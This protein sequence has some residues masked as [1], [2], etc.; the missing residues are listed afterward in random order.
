[1]K[2]KKVLKS[3]AIILSIILVPLDIC[4]YMKMQS[5]WS[6][7]VS[8]QEPYENAS[9]AI[10]GFFRWGMLIG[11]ILLIPMVWLEYLLI[12]LLIKIYNKFDGLK[13]LFF[14]FTTICCNSN[15][16]SFVYKNNNIYYN[17]TMI[18]DNS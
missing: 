4:L 9:L 11:G 15:N 10:V 12:N 17:V 13:R 2:N 6:E 18:N 1:M 5:T 14:L 16:I 7:I 8:N 3:I